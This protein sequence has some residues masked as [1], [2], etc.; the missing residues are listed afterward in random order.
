MTPGP[1]AGGDHPVALGQVQGHRLLDDDVLA[2][3]G[4]QAGRLA[5]QVVGQAEHDQ[6]DLG[7]VE[8]RRKSVKW[9]GIPRSAANRS[10]WPGVGDA[11][12]T[13]WAPGTLRRASWWIDVMK[14]EPI[15]PTRTVSVAVDMIF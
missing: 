15:R 7:E 2:R 13:T 10:A 12:A 4:G 1:L 14:P 9:W 11:T 5:V 3:L 6:V 8:Q